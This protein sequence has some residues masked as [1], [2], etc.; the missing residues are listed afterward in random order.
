M[1]NLIGRSRKNYI[2]KSHK[3]RNTQLK[4]IRISRTK[5]FFLFFKTYETLE[6]GKV[7]IKLFFLKKF[8]AT[9]A[10]GIPKPST[11]AAWHWNP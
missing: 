9:G 11:G 6:M 10:I 8:S 5:Y 2:Y 3:N 7:Y 1:K 4:L